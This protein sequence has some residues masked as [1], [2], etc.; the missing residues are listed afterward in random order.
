MRHS[1]VLVIGAGITGLATAHALAEEGASVTVVDAYGPAAMASGWTLAG[2]RQSGRDPAELQ[3]ARE[4]VALWANLDARLDAPTG[5]RRSGNLRLARTEAEAETIRALVNTQA[6]AGLDIVLMQGA[7]L[8]SFAS[9]LSESIVCASFCASDGQAEPDATAQAFAGAA[10]CLGVQI[11]SGVRVHGFD[12]EG[13]RFRAV[14]TGQGRISAGAC[15]V[16]AGIGTPALLETLGLALPL[17]TPLVAVVQTE[18]IAPCLTP[19][20]GVANADLAA[21]QQRDGRLRVSSGLEPWPGELA[22]DERGQPVARPSAGTISA[23]LQRVA[24][25][26]PAL[27]TAPLARFWGG[28]ID[29]TPDGL[30]VIDRAPGIA[31]LFVAA[32]FSGHGFGIGPAV[33]RALGDLILGRG[34]RFA[35]DAFRFDRFGEGQD[36]MAPLTLHG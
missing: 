8:R 9:A 35:I 13:G 29:L 27:E 22:H 28:V 4:A 21:R 19:V 1:D 3:L 20:L 7:E 16:A 17:R 32:G 36:R 11:R 33:G 31:G 18:P 30:P 24:Q 26:L 5:Y 14:E 25:V 2:V 10:T 15:L 23:M 34:S 12:I 6:A